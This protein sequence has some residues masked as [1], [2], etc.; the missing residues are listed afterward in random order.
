MTQK[1]PENRRGGLIVRL[2][3]EKI[4][5]NRGALLTLAVANPDYKSIGSE[6]EYALHQLGD[7]N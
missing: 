6:F 2:P 1:W 3:P 7:K 5:L 4:G